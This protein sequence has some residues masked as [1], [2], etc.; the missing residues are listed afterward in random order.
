LKVEGL[1]KYVGV[2]WVG[3]NAIKKAGSSSGMEL[4]GLGHFEGYEWVGIN[5]IK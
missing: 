3:I 4:G 1:G 5:A 2:E